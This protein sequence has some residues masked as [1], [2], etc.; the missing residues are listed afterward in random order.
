MTEL[1]RRVDLKTSASGRNVRHSESFRTSIES[2][3]LPAVPGGN[4]LGH[5]WQIFMPTSL[6]LGGLAFGPRAAVCLPPRPR[7]CS[8]AHQR[9]RQ[10]PSRRN[11]GPEPGHC[12]LSL[13]L[14]SEAHCQELPLVVTSELVELRA[15]GEDTARRLEW[16]FKLHFEH[17]W[18]AG[19]HVAASGCHCGRDS[20]SES[21]PPL[22]PT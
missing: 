4:Q 5:S 21:A 13:R 22:V 8:S 3:Q 20:E 9:A 15:K 6:G 17:R 1:R 16:P 12:I 19:L 2:C 14:D 10:A 11:E 18:Q 7:R